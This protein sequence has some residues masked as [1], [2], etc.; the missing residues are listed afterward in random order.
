MDEITREELIEKIIEKTNC[1]E[2]EVTTYLK[3]GD[4]YVDSLPADAD[5]IDGD[6]QLDYIY[7]N[8]DLDPETIEKISDAEFELLYK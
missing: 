5:S 2:E 6:E 7:S 4:E 1:T 8:S 3:T